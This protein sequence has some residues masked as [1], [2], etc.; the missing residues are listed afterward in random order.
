MKNWLLGGVILLLGTVVGG[1][2]TAQ[3]S[4]QI[5]Q[6]ICNVDS[7][8]TVCNYVPVGSGAPLNVTGV[9]G[10]SGFA[11]T[12]A[13]AIPPLTV[14][15]TS[16]TVALPAG[17]VVAVYNVGANVAYTTIGTSPV[18]TAAMDAIQPGGC[19][20]Y[21]RGTATTLAAIE[22]AGATTL[23]LS[24]GSTAPLSCGG[25]GSGEAVA[26]QGTPAAIA[27]AWPTYL[28]LGGAVLSSTNALPIDCS[29]AGNTL[30]GLINSAIPAGTNII[31]SVGLAA[32][33]A[34]GST[35]YGLVAP[36]TVTAEQIDAN[37][38]TLYDVQLSNI[39][40][41]AAWLHLYNLASATCSSATGAVGAAILI[42]ANST[43]ALGAGNN[44][45]F[46]PIGKL[47]STGI[48]YCISGGQA[49][50]DTTAISATSITINADYK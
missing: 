11:P 26:N 9:G 23:N 27:N 35:A 45:A 33:A 38:G 2:A 50:G 46:G 16:S 22:T 19:F 20:A 4:V 30:C 25:G 47:F 32:S 40:A 5:V 21:T 10:G 14:G 37:P 18:A 1:V 31:G 28:S 34:N 24:G 41:T 8:V 6:Q 17:A 12:P 13:Y 44:V 29:S 42:P 36:A 48:S 43:A 15:A 7:G 39:S 49:A 3:Q